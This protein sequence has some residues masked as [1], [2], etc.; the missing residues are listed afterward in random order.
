MKDWNG[1]IRLRRSQPHA[2][3]D[4]NLAHRAR[5]DDYAT[6]M[7]IDATKLRLR[8]N[9]LATVVR[10]VHGSNPRPL[11]SALCQKRTFC[12]A[13]NNTLF[14]HLIGAVATDRDLS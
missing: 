8:L 5:T 6:T 4:K 1:A 2:G 7:L 14:D 10:N 11:M 13:A 12:T 9:N 3:I